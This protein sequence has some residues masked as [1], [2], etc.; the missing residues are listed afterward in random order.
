MV[1]GKCVAGV[2]CLCPH[3]GTTPFSCIPWLAVPSGAHF[4]LDAPGGNDT[5]VGSA[6]RY[7]WLDRDAGG[8]HRQ[9]TRLLYGPTFAELLTTPT[10]YYSRLMSDGFIEIT[11]VTDIGN[12]PDGTPDTIVTVALTPKAREMLNA[13]QS[14]PALEPDA[15]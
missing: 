10:D 13:A 9:A 4:R 7:R 12:R 15:L 14:N 5:V 11:S 6:F 1:L 3:Y 8:V 2:L